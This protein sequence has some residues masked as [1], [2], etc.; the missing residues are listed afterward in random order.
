M[1][2]LLHC[3]KNTLYGCILFAGIKPVQCTAPSFVGNLSAK[4]YSAASRNRRHSDTWQCEIN[5]PKVYLP[6]AGVPADFSNLSGFIITNFLEQKKNSWTPAKKLQESKSISTIGRAKDLS[7]QELFLADSG[8]TIV[9]VPVTGQL[10]QVE[11]ALPAPVV[12]HRRT[13]AGDVIETDR[14]LIQ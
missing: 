3:L 8:K 7:V 11:L 13:L 12:E 2:H 1:H 4:E 6:L 10:K 14:C 5:N 9:A